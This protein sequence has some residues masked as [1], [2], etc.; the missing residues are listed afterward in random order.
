MLAII[1]GLNRKKELSQVNSANLYRFIFLKTIEREMDRFAKVYN[2]N[3][4]H[5]IHEIYTQQGGPGTSPQIHTAISQKPNYIGLR[6]IAQ[7]RIKKNLSVNGT[8]T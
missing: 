3:I 4:P 7:E 8:T 2:N 5:Y 1:L 6:P